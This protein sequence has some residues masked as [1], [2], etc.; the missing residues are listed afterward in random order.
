MARPKT[1]YADPN[2]QRVP[3]VTTVIGILDKPALV[4]W[5]GK[6]CAEAGWWAAKNDEPVPHWREVCYGI[7]E[8]RFTTI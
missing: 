3:G 5:A 6:L 2:G 8:F 7:R 4:G 1:G